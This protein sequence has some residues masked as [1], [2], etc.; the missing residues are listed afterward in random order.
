[1]SLLSFC[2]AVFCIL[3]TLAL[4]AKVVTA[5][6]F[7]VDPEHGSMNNDGSKE[8]PWSTFSAVVA[9]CKIQTRKYS[10]N[11]PTP[12][13]SYTTKCPSG[14]V[15]AG[16]TIYL[17]SGYHGD[18]EIW[19]ALNTDYITVKA[20]PDAEPRFRHIKLLACSNWI[21]DGIYISP[22]YTAPG[23]AP[24]AIFEVPYN[25]FQGP[26]SH[27]TLKN[28]KVFSVPSITGFSVSD[29][30]TKTFTGVNISHTDSTVIDNVHIYNINL[31]L[32]IADSP[33]SEIKNSTI[34]NFRSDG[35]FAYQ[36]NYTKI[37]YNTV[38]NAYDLTEGAGVHT[39]LMQFSSNGIMDNA[40]TGLEVRGNK[41]IAHEDEHQ[42]FLG[43]TQGISGFDG[44]YKDF[45]IENNVVIAGTNHGMSYYGAIDCR[46]INNT[47]VIPWES[48]TYQQCPILIFNHKNGTKSTGN[49]VRNNL[50]TQAY[51]ISGS[52]IMDNNQFIQRA[53]YNDHF[54]DAANFNFNLK[55]SSPVVNIG[56]TNLSPKIDIMKIDRDT[57][58][59]IGAYEYTQA[60][61]L[62][63]PQ[64][65]QIEISK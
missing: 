41:V 21:F 65:Y 23:T 48:D 29:W 34:E 26:S 20:A 56:S 63:A 22:S 36:S 3:F 18:I 6:D 47:L 53:D 5:T 57:N 59:D 28:S 55:S 61:S 10:V 60:N 32:G 49:I 7:Y 9:A 16:D 62:T 39:D 40:F 25:S 19:Q 11:N 43:P 52:G 24:A 51:M 38:K 12:P 2:R 50:T 64:L 13:Y 58:P 46:I 27:I 44:F 15:H 30:E 54:V 31:G 33:N 35:L 1:M 14:P 17:L 4:S 42:P 37:E 8:H 45:V